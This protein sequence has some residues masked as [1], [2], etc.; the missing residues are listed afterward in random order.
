MA[1]AMNHAIVAL[2]PIGVLAAIGYAF[3]GNENPNSWEALFWLS[4]IVNVV[5]FVLLADA[6]ARLAGFR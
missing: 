2:L 5:L 1:K 4:G 3:Q 6:K